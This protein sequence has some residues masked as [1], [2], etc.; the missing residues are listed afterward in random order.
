MLDF[1]FL[2]YLVQFRP[3]TD[4]ALNTIQIQNEFAILV[5]DYHLLCFTDYIMLAETKNIVG[6]SFV[7]CCII[8][9]IFPNLWLF[10]KDFREQ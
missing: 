3:Y 1:L 10:I 7:V 2:M 6:W 5:I 9:L 8:N 4:E